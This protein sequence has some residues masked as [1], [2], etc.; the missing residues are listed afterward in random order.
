MRLAVR[1]VCF[2]ALLCGVAA[3]GQTQIN[4][5]TQIRWPSTANSG[6][7]TLPCNAA[8][9]GQPYTDITNNKGYM[10]GSSGWFLSGGNAT[11]GGSNCQLQLNSSGIFGG[12]SGNSSC[13]GSD[14]NVTGA[15]EPNG[16]QIDPRNTL[17][18]VQI[19]TNTDQSAAMQAA[20][21]AASGFSGGAT[22]LVPGSIRIFNAITVPSNVKLMG[23]GPNSNIYCSNGSTL[24]SI[25]INLGTNASNVTI[26]DLNITADTNG[27]TGANEIIVGTTPQNITIRNVTITGGQGADIFFF[28][29]NNILIDHPTLT[30][31]A[32]S[33]ILTNGES[34]S[35]SVTTGLLINSPVVYGGFGA[36]P[37]AL[38]LYSCQHCTVIGGNIDE[39]NKALVTTSGGYGILFYTIQF[40][41]MPIT[42][43]SCPTLTCT[44]TVPGPFNVSLASLTGTTTV[45]LGVPSGTFATQQIGTLITTTV[46][47]VVGGT[48]N[49]NGAHICTIASTSTCTYAVSGGNTAGVNISAATASGF[50]FLPMA[51][52]DFAVN[53]QGGINGSDLSF[54]GSQMATAV[55]PTTFTVTYDNAPN[56]GT[57]NYSN[58]VSITGSNGNLTGTVASGLLPPIGTTFSIDLLNPSGT[59]TGNLGG[60]FYGTG[61]S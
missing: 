14:L 15:V 31:F 26:Q 16:P 23:T 53:F 49:L 25:C 22:V 40:T 61:P 37:G 17:Y 2:L 13:N 21:N 38:T 33:A 7:P 55:S 8:N 51:G 34:S 19:G 9:Y 1:F 11:P 56:L 18:G 58:T 43:V 20:I 60:P 5:N 12:A 57:F 39:N 47:G 29:G 59:F 27:T 10:C 4:P 44:F 35:N 54:L 6:A 45:T 28:G 3:H 36:N 32:A 46:A 48:G 30:G 24:T 52:V 42:N 41:Q 50:G